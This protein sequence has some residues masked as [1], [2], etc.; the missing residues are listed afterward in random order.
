MCIN[1]KFG[2]GACLIIMRESERKPLRGYHLLGCQYMMKNWR[3]IVQQ[4]AIRATHLVEY[5]WSMRHCPISSKTGM[6]ELENQCSCIGEVNLCVPPRYI[7]QQ[8]WSTI[9][10]STSLQDLVCVDYLTCNNMQ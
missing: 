2:Q 10:S 4:E 7:W 3:R 9:L 1:K 6:S 5:V 8:S